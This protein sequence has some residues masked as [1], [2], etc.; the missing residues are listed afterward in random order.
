MC[1]KRK[2][3]NLFHQFDVGFDFSIFMKRN[4]SKMK[5]YL[6]LNDLNEDVL[7]IIFDKCSLDDLLNLV[8]VCK[9]FQAIIRQS[10][11]LRRSLDLLLVGHR[12]RNAI[13]YQR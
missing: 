6:L 11:F 7:S 12:N 10:T 2:F 3:N 13:S 9:R 8:Y 1:H 4:I 5:K